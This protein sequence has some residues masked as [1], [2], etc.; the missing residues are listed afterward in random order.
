MH[1]VVSWDISETP[2][3][4]YIEQQLQQV[5]LPYVPIKP[6]TTFYIVQVL[7][8]TEYSTIIQRLTA[9]AQVYPQWVRF[10]VTPLMVGGS[11]NG[12]LDAGYWPEIQRRTL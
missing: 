4:Q 7:T 11:Y 9:V 2:Q 3:R 5:L 8:Q 12:W 6:L 1:F 10:V